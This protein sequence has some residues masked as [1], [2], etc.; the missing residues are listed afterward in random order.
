MTDADLM[1]LTRRQIVA[2][3]NRHGVKLPHL[4]H[5]RKALLAEH[6][7]RAVMVHEAELARQLAADEAGMRAGDFDARIEDMVWA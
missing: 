1:P 2:T 5:Y 6:V 3:A 4:T 7:A